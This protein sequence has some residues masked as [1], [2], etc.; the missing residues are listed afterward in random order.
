MGEREMSRRSTPTDSADNGPSSSAQGR[1]RGLARMEGGVGFVKT[2][3]TNTN[4]LQSALRV[5]AQM[6]IYLLPSTY[7][8]T[9]THTGRSHLTC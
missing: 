8:Y 6:P 5:K 4:A 7:M 2:C 9:R 1:D 3:V